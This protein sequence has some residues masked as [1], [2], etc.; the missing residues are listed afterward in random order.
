VIVQKIDLR[1][2][3]FELLR[4]FPAS[5]QMNPPTAGVKYI[6]S[7]ASLIPFILETIESD[8]DEPIRSVIDVFTGTTRVAQAFRLQ[9]WNVV[10][11][12]LS[13][14][15]R[16][17]SGT[18]ISGSANTHLQQRIDQLN[19][20]PGV[21]GWITKNYC[22]VRAEGNGLVRVWQVKNGRRADAIRDKI[23]EWSDSG[24]LAQ[25]EIDTLITSL[26]IALDRVDNTVGV[27]Q[28]Y[29]KDWCKRSFNDMNL[30][31]PL[32][33]IGP[34]GSHLSGD[35][36]E[37]DY[38]TADLAYLDPP[39]SAHSYSTYYH[40]WDSIAAWDK[41]AVGLKTNRRVDRIASHEEFDT[42][43]ASLWNSKKSALNAFEKLVKRL[44]VKNVLISYNNESLVPIETLLKV[45]RKIGAVT[46]H[47]I[48][49]KR[50]IMSQIGNAALGGATEFV[51]ENKEY[52][53]MVAK[54]LTAAAP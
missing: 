19:A 20:L 54:N 28:A 10:T 32:A 38:P 14:A 51:T 53:L 43:M 46:V 11:S 44:P 5:K 49:Y 22:D 47:E 29:L 6:G 40:I 24:E 3:K 36:L 17:Y 35:C 39:Y 16:V 45:L 25:W 50:N 42:H 12:D 7:K 4:T 34:V 23:E 33:P 8:I 9:G 30:E 41:P 26:I 48:D 21:D 13:W 2:S 31:L 52:L 15:S 37:L 27:Q 1:N 18:W